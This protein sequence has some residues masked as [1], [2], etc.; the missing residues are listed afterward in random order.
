MSSENNAEAKRVQFG[1][2][3]SKCE[4]QN[5]IANAVNRSCTNCLIPSID[6]PIIMLYSNSDK[7][8]HCE[9]QISLS[10]CRFGCMAVWLSVS[11]IYLALFS[12]V[13]EDNPLHSSH[14]SGCPQCGTGRGVASV[15]QQATWSKPCTVS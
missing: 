13:C 5:P 6:K 3:L 7:L 15:A 4:N 10:I 2:C 11:A 12:L 9:L 1:F 14:L 8:V